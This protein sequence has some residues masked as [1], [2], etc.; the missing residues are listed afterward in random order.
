MLTNHL[1]IFFRDSQ[2]TQIV[3]GFRGRHKEQQI[4]GLF[5]SARSMMLAA[6]R[7]SLGVP[8]VVVTHN[9]F[10][11]Q[12][13]ADD[14]REWLGTGRVLTYP[15]NEVLTAELSVASPEM[16]AQRIATLSVMADGFDGV[17]V[18]PYAG[19]RRLLPPRDVLAAARIVLHKGAEYDFNALRTSMVELGYE[20]AHQV[21]NRGEFSVRGGILD[22]FPL[23]TDTAYR[24]EFFGNEIDSI[25]TF[26]AEDQRSGNHLSEVVV[27]PCRETFAS[28]E[29]FT[30]AAE[31]AREWLN[32]Q[33]AV[34][35]DVAMK[36]SLQESIGAELEMLAQ[37]QA[38]P[39]MYKYMA[40]LYPEKRTLF[41]YFSSD[42][43]I[44]MDEPTRLADVA[45]QMD[46]D[47]Q[48]WR[49]E[50]SAVGNML[51]AF[52]W[53]IPS[54]EVFHRH[55]HR[56]LYLSRL[57]ANV[58]IGKPSESVQYTCAEL[59]NYFGRLDV[60]KK[61]VS[62]WRKAG[63]KVVFI[64]SDDER[65][66]RL[67]RM[68]I[69]FKIE[70]HEILEGNL[71]DGFE[72]PTLRLVIIGETEMFHNRQRRVRTEQKKIENALTIKSYK[73]LN[74]GDF[75]VHVHHGIGQ[76]TGIG[77]IVIEGVHRDF[78]HINYAGGDR[79]SVPIDQI[80]LVQKYMGNDDRSPKV[81]RLGGAEWARAKA[82]ARSSAKD[83]ADELIKLYAERAARQGY[84]FARD[85]PEQQEFESMF[86][87]E[88]TVD[89]LRAI[90]E[91]KD[92]MELSRPMDRLLCG[93]VGYGKTEVAIRA[94]FKAIVDGKQVAVLVPT[95]ILAQQHYKTFVDRFASFP[96]Q[97]EVLSRFRSAAD[98][99]KVMEKLRK[100]LVDVVIGTHR[101][102]SKDIQFK[103]LGLLIVD[104]E[105]RFGVSHKEKLKKLRSDVDVLTLTATPIPRTLHMSLIG[106][107]D[108]SVIETPP[109]NR[110]PVQTYVVE[111]SF[112]LAR[113]VIERELERQGQVF[114]MYNR[115]QGMETIVENLRTLLPHARI[116]MAHGQ[117]PE[118]LLERTILDFLDGEYDVLVSTSIIESGVDIPS[119]NTLIV[120]DAD[121]LGLSQLYQL[122]GRVGRSAGRIAYA[123]FT[124][125]RNK[126]LTE[127]AEQRLSAIKQFTELGSGFKIAMRD[128]SIRGA[129][130]LLGAEQ[131]GFIAAVG[132]ELYTQMLAEEIELRKQELNPQSNEEVALAERPAPDLQIVIDAYLPSLYIYDSK[133]KI[134]IYKRI[135]AIESIAEADELSE[136]MVDRF[137]KMPSAVLNLLNIAK[138]KLYGT[139][140]GLEKY[141]YKNGRLTIL[142]SVLQNERIDD[143]RLYDLL[144]QYKGTMRL[145][146]SGLNKQREL[147]FQDPDITVDKAVQ[148]L[149]AFLEA[150]GE[151]HIP[152]GEMANVEKV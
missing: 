144:K 150:F 103:D 66:E 147:Q 22:F 50:M 28:V 98:V 124:Y 77:T 19:L 59:P 96:V 25:R 145:L 4:I 142:V 116:T 120:H 26:Q 18:L 127:V 122:R 63:C 136:E 46:Y 44:V 81:H 40:Q 137:G 151:V 104:E 74:V 130:N 68:L 110:L 32:R 152:R 119:V 31:H 126:V 89:Q 34:T 85:I 88:A 35:T 21:E 39:A 49:E 115:V 37:Q 79:L 91:I 7:Q 86:Q 65:R 133:Q 149:V 13:L 52:Q 42:T 53:A 23:V 58:P 95:T 64:G 107:R 105:Q 93:D 56:L 24:V 141:V 101:L 106:V 148:R 114:Y 61:D 129:G 16:M 29:R 3:D 8:L 117:M 62:R 78:M 17:L 6:L 71:Q 54:N 102:L 84:A 113:D 55:P 5:G 76:Y 15:V 134:E 30:K 45:N 83:I 135:A 97:V 90:R 131:S 128:L 139:R 67:R 108:L 132:F 10:S 123:Y 143:K 118:Q 47:E 36:R 69:D 1:D 140:Y 9:M 121:K 57:V 75:V 27:T 100:G 125:Q 51:P 38:F 82:K 33:L 72:L 14:M 60:L 43:L 70:Y 2:F 41:D 111:H 94:S 99:K 87:Y 48:R 11:A 92:D 146:V 20:H 73:E 112:A 109:E 80:A 12:K 138:L